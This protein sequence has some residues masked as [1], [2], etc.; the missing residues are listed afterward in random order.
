[1]SKIKPALSAFKQNKARIDPWMRAQVT[2]VNDSQ[3]KAAWETFLGSQ[4]A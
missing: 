2:P 1:M 4:T 3:T